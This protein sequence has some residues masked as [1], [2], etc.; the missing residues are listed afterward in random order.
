MENI[1]VQMSSQELSE[2]IKAYNTLKVFL[3][4]TVSPT[5]RYNYEFLKNMKEIQAEMQAKNDDTK[6]KTVKKYRFF[7]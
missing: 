5:D 1:T 6:Q 3:D 7:R 4:K 2:M